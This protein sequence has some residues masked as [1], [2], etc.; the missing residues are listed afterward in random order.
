[1]S[2]SSEPRDDEQAA[3]LES[4]RQAEPRPV[5]VKLGPLGWARF[6]W[7]QLT[8]MRVALLLLLLLAVAAVP[9]SL[10]PQRSADPNGV[11]KYFTDHPDLAPWLDR[12]SM[13]DVYSSPWF[14][15]VYVLLFISLIGCVLPRIKHH[16]QAL[17]SKPPK[18]PA[19][20]ER[21]ETYERLTV[22][23]A[24]DAVVDAADRILKSRRYRRARFDRP[25]RRSVPAGVSVSAE[26]GYA[27]ETGNLVFHLALVGVL[28][29]VGA[30]SGVGYYG[31]RVIVQGTTFPNTL[32]SYDSFSAGRWVN[33]SN[34]TP[35]EITLDSF[36][37]E[38]ADTL[39]DVQSG[40]YGQAIDYTAAVTVHQP[41]GT[42]SAE[43]IKV[44]HPL[45]IDGT[46]VFLLG[47][48]Y[49]PV[50]TVRDANG[51]V[52]FSD[53]VPFLPQDANLTS[54]GI[55]KVTD[56][57]PEQLGLV[58]YFY[59]TAQEAHEGISTSVYPALDNPVLS[60][61]VYAGDLGVDQGVPKSVYTLD[62]DT[63]TQ[64][65][66]GTAE[67]SALQLKPGETVDLP[68]GRGTITFDEVRPYVSLELRNDASQV[69]VLAFALTAVIGLLSSL[70]IPR[71]RVWVVATPETSDTVDAPGRTVV[72]VAGLARGDD[73]TLD[74]AVTRIVA[75]LREE[76]GEPAPTVPDDVA[77][78]GDPETDEH[79]RR[80]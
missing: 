25:A 56:I 28:L 19:R 51:E 26:R 4:G 10:F 44:N 60:L 37:T 46:N 27:R 49:A 71:R 69:W 50:I 77:E 42:T 67:T 36:T 72:E 80:R 70:F 63:L 53:P 24:P 54:L 17:F 3:S 74:E 73:H 11:T 18:T 78:P 15:A 66:G 76:L 40:A 45:N 52:V 57:E 65:A 59:P 48:G 9:G 22:D 12:I 79:A 61:N 75:R 30:G 7:R 33:G 58:G 8:S 39:A 31:Q 13:F 64:I 47:N 34:L 38:Y 21:L 14:A 68:E 6:I 29:A 55:V 1:M 16:W 5:G 43:Q 23:A 62:I 32:S 2:H 35:F 41:D 20:L